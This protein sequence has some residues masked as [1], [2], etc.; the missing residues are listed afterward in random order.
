MMQGRTLPHNKE[1]TKEITPSGVIAINR[2]TQLPQERPSRR[3]PNRTMEK[4]ERL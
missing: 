2:R 3:K 4:K 1:I